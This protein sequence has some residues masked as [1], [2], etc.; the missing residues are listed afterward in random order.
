[1]RNLDALLVE[2]CEHL[3]NTYH[4]CGYS[5]QNIIHKILNDPGIS[6]QGSKHRVLWWPKNKRIARMSRAFHYVMPLA[7]VCLIVEYGKILKDD[8]WIL[9][10]KEFCADSGY[11][12]ALFDVYVKHAKKQLRYILKTY[13]K[14]VKKYYCIG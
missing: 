6:T 4:R 10:K 1:M 5:G 3:V 11:S 12:C 9:T 14:S 2:Y 7:R 13:E 8:G